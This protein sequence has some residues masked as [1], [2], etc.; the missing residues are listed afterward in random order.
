MKKTSSLH[1]EE[2]IWDEIDNYKVAYKLSSRNAALERMLLER[3]FLINKDNSMFID[4]SKIEQK[5]VQSEEKKQS[6]PMLDN[7]Y[8][9][10]E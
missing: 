8:D 3:R 4:T 7:I 10:M 9:N 1:L 2:D 6:D 5:Y